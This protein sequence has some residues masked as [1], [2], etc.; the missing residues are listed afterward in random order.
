MTGST[1]VIVTGNR[2][3]YH[4][5]LSPSAAVEDWKKLE[6]ILKKGHDNDRIYLWGRIRRD[7]SFKFIV[8]KR[9]AK[10]NGLERMTDS[11]LRSWLAL[12]FRDEMNN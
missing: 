5:A 7:G 2:A 1:K 3:G 6:G 10:E 9:L 12:L 8:T 4:V 11:Q